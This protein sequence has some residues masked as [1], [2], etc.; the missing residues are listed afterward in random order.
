MPDFC[1]P[2]LP[3][4]LVHLRYFQQFTGKLAGSRASILSQ[5]SPAVFQV[6]YLKYYSMEGPGSFGERYC[7][8]EF[9]RHVGQWILMRRGVLRL[10]HSR[11]QEIT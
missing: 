3:R 2:F 6:L 8:T 11:K 10:A 1:V 7:T 9:N 4:H 5:P